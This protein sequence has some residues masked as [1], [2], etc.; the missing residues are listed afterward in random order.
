MA[1]K[2]VADA[3]LR[4]AAEREAQRREEIAAMFRRVRPAAYLAHDRWNKYDG[5]EYERLAG[6]VR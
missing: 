5:Y 1:A 4:L 3:V 2:L 6:E